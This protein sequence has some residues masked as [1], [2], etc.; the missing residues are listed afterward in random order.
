MSSVLRSFSQTPSQTLW[1]EDGPYLQTYQ[2]F[3]SA[4]ASYNPSYVGNLILFKSE[5][6]LGDAVY[7]LEDSSPPE[8][9]S[10]VSLL[11]M[12]KRVYLGVSGGE[13]RHFT[14]KLVR[15]ENGAHRGEVY[16]VLA[17]VYQITP[18][19]YNGLDGYGEVWV[20]RGAV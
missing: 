7:D 10:H 4:F 12:G 15:V 1:S 19:I 5:A 9:S 8:A 18:T 17:G 14:Y 16:Y 3:E 13:S 6:D 2:S 20:G 11:D